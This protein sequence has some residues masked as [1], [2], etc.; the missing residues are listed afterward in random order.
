VSG[1]KKVVYVVGAGLS[2]GLGFPTISNLLAGLWPRLLDKGMAD[3]LAEV[4]RFHHPSF[5]PALVDTFPN[6]EELL[7]EMQANSQLF[8]SSRPATGKFTSN[9]LDERRQGLLLELAE[10]FH[11]IQAKAL[12]DPPSW[13]VQLVDAIRAEEAQIV[14]L[15]W[16]L[17][18][19]E[20]LFGNALSRADYALTEKQKGPRLIKPHGS[21]NWYEAR[22]GRHLR[23]SKKFHL[24]GEG[25]DEVYA[26]RPYR[27]PSSKRRRYMPFIVPPVYGK[28]FHG[29]LSRRLWRQTVSVISTASEVRFMGYSL[30]TADFHA[31]F[32]L[33]CGLHNQESGEL[34]RN[35]S[36][37]HAT[38]R[39]R[40]T[41]IDPSA[42]GAIRIEAAVGWPCQHHVQTIEDWV[43]G[44]G[45]LRP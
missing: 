20:L 23:A 36:R 16:D 43:G 6:I 11:E 32:I 15:N 1:Q 40:V 41:I 2:A 39:A 10:W 7:S 9:E 37:A 33:R 31:R 19:D 26:F 21:L 13:L 14:S 35:G 34:K 5:N 4:I 27:A 18:L 24:C 8:G 25:D 38:G 29:E 22:S 30:P 45:L 28:E 42:D 44:G 17:V 3:N 12:A